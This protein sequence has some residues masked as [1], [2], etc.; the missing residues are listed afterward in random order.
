[1]T[2]LSTLP[3]IIVGILLVTKEFFLVRFLGGISLLFTGA[4]S[5]IFWST[6]RLCSGENLFVDASG[7]FVFHMLFGVDT[8]F[9]FYRHETVFQFKSMALCIIA[10]G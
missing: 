6:L 8:L 4:G 2:L 7:S 1:M 9:L 5:F 3:F 10:V